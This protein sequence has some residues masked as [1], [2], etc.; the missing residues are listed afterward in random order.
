MRA[1]GPG[2]TDL[3]QKDRPAE[4]AMRVRVGTNFLSQFKAIPPVQPRSKK[5][6][7]G[8]VGQIK[9][10]TPAILSHQRGVGHRR[11]RGAG[12]DGREGCD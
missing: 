1:S 9:S 5:Y 4:P 7:A 6:F 2:R 10:I 3:H 12:S 8:P 11:K